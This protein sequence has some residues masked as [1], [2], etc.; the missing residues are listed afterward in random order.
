MVL[1]QLTAFSGKVCAEEEGGGMRGIPLR[2]SR[3][4]VLVVLFQLL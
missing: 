4:I 3:T 1:S 2:L